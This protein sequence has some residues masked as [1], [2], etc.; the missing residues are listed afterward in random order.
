VSEK[1]FMSEHC[2]EDYIRT[3]KRKVLLLCLPST[4]LTWEALQGV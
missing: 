1:G 2:K 4:L 3:R